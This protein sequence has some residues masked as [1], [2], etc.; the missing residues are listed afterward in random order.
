[1][2]DLYYHNICVTCNE[3][4][5]VPK[6]FFGSDIK[7]LSCGPCTRLIK[8]KQNEKWEEEAKQKKKLNPDKYCIISDCN[9]ERYY[10]N[11]RCY[12]H[13]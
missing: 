1:M 7:G 4:F 9:S 5:D 11:D 13:C 8:C 6:T 2:K 3:P 10:N 12:Y